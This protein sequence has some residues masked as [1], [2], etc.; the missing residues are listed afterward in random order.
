MFLG[1]TTKCF[2]VRT[3]SRLSPKCFD[4]HMEVAVQDQGCYLR[5]A[6]ALPV[7]GAGHGS[8]SWKPQERYFLSKSVVAF[9]RNCVHE[10]CIIVLVSNFI[11]IFLLWA[12]INTI[13]Q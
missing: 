8:E 13:S 1:V 10:R 2:R 5:A 11:L 3:Y 4:V 7:G 9:M 12:V 6:L